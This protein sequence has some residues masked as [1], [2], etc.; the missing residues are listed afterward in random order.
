MDIENVYRDYFS[1]VYRYI[2]S[3]SRDPLTAEEITQET[4]FKALK[5][6]DDFRGDSSIRVW[7]CG[8]AK[9]AYLDH[10]K[11]QNKLSELPEELAEPAPSVEDAFF[12]SADAKEIHRIL[13]S[14]REP[15]KEVFSLRTFGE[16]AFS[17]IAELFGKSES[18]AR[19]TY[20]RARMMIKEEMKND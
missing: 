12:L 2:L 16:L 3:L 8:I 13:H 9:N 1:V 15:Y 17:D 19:V 7:L 20:H 10:V 6:I 4:F 11:R 5:K 18:W 14:L